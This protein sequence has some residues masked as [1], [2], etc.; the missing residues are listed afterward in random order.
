MLPVPGE[1]MTT[2]DVDDEVDAAA[3]EH[4]EFQ[5]DGVT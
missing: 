4:S 5:V 1:T 3:V 2:Q